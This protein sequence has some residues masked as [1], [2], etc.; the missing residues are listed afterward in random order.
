MFA[1]IL[2][3]SFGYV[4]IAL[5][6]FV[7]LCLLLG[8]ARGFAK[9]LNGI[10]LS[11]TIV[12]ISM[13]LLGLTLEPAKEFSLSQKLN[14]ALIEESAEWG[15]SFNEPIYETDDGLKLLHDEKYIKISSVDG[16]KGKIANWLAE[17]YI[18]ED[19]QTVAG[20][21]VDNISSLIISIVL[22]LL[23]CIA[24]GVV[25]A[26]VRKASHSLSDSDSSAILVV[27]RI[28]GSVVGCTLACVT[29]LFIFGIFASLQDKMPS[30]IEYIKGNIVS[31]YVYENNPVKV[32]FESIFTNY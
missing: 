10:L 7:V 22:F 29:V 32:V 9:S 27:D 16:T 30:A 14:N 19:G 8:L 23:Y 11:V 18:D 17:K 20:V 2:S 4:D 21:I 25:F 15:D 1:E 13:F 31:G 28:L 24:F 3:A 6:A 26:F 12:L 5:I